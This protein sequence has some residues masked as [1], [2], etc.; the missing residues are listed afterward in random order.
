MGKR[1][2]RRGSPHRSKP[3]LPLSRI[4]E[5]LENAL[6][7]IRLSREE[8]L[9]N[10]GGSSVL[11]DPDPFAAIGGL[12]PWQQSAAS[13]PLPIYSTFGPPAQSKPMRLRCNLMVG[14]VER[15]SN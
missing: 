5:Q 11:S 2:P 9:Q 15:S 1:P 4:P 14:A 6:Q 12:S 10:L 13:T 3:G 7:A 8:G